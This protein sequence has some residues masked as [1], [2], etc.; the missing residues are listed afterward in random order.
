MFGGSLQPA[1]YELLCL[2]D[3]IAAREASEWTKLK[4]LILRAMGGRDIASVRVSAPLR[5]SSE[6]RN[7]LSLAK[8]KGCL[9][10]H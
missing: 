4:E 8:V 2:R 6:G 10:H 9:M 7:M 5:L 3:A 1:R